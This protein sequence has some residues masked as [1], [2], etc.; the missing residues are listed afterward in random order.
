MTDDATSLTQILAFYYQ[1]GDAETGELIGVL[2]I[3]IF[4]L[5]LFWDRVSQHSPGCPGIQNIDHAPQIQRPTHLCP[6]AL[7][8]KAYTTI[9]SVF[10]L[11]PDSGFLIYTPEESAS[12]ACKFESARHEKSKCPFS[13]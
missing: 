4:L 1:N 8:L 3:I 9:S 6:G 5:L 7:G 12:Y 2:F 11:F 13:A 10:V